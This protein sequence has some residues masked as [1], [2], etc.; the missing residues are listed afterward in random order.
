MNE[1]TKTYD[2]QVTTHIDLDYDF[3]ATHYYT[4]PDTIRAQV[5][6]EMSDYFEGVLQRNHKVVSFAEVVTQAAK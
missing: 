6:I 3:V 1:Q 5:L 4:D 2:I